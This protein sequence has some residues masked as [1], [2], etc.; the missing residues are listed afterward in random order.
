MILNLNKNEYLLLAQLEPLLMIIKRFCEIIC[1]RHISIS[2]QSKSKSFIGVY[3]FMTNI[4]RFT[5]ALENSGLIK[6]NGEE[7][8]KFSLD[9]T[10]FTGK[11]S[12]L[13][14]SIYSIEHIE[15]KMTFID[16]CAIIDDCK[17]EF[18]DLTPRKI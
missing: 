9:G 6:Y 10:Y 7:L 14:H 13:S 8:D 15:K 16:N 3:F 12:C 17:F 11:T 4:Q 18:F 1:E 5:A 2:S